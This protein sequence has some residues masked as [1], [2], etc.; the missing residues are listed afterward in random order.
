MSNGSGGVPDL[1]DHTNV[2][3]MG[4]VVASPGAVGAIPQGPLLTPAPDIVQPDVPSAR[5]EAGGCPWTNCPHH[6]AAQLPAN[7]CRVGPT[8]AVIADHTPLSGTVHFQP[9]GALPR[10][11]HQ[12]QLEGLCKNTRVTPAPWDPPPKLASPQLVAQ[13]PSHSTA[14]TRSVG[15]DDG[16]PGWRTQCCK[17]G[18]GKLYGTSMTS[19]APVCPA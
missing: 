12:L 17:G 9:P 3:L 1:A 7:H 6:P 4:V 5:A 14:A 16:C 15:Q 18:R 13:S 10:A 19:T 11:T 8:S 2:L